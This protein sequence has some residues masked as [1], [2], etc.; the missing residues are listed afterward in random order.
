MNQPDLVP[1]FQW[2]AGIV[3]ATIPLMLLDIAVQVLAAF[4]VYNDAKAGWDKSPAMWGVLVGFFGL[5]PLIVYLAMRAGRR[6]RRCPQCSTLVKE[7]A[8]SCPACL[9]VFSPADPAD[10]A[11]EACR[12]RVK[13]LAV[14]AIVL[15]AFTFVAAMV[16]VVCIISSMPS[17]MGQLQDN[18]SF[19][20]SFWIR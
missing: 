19:S 12:R 13:P 14:T 9:H 17:M 8:P 20:R 16:L 10:P 2:T 4:A 18:F 1:I 6:S 3:L 15:Y 5:I 11:V 7:A